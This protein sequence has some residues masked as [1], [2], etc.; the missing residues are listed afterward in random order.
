MASNLQTQPK[1]LYTTS[2]INGSW[3]CSKITPFSISRSSKTHNT[4]FKN[5]YSTFSATYIAYFL[6]QFIIMFNIKEKS[7]NFTSGTTTISLYECIRLVHVLLSRFYPDFIL[8]LSWFY[9]DFILILSWFYPNIILIY[10]S[11]FHMDRPLF[12]R[13][14][15]CSIWTSLVAARPPCYSDLP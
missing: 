3:N 15:L 7:K 13:S 2:E 1:R 12:A 14:N 4:I 8:I 5:Q 10:R 9:P 11:T 6:I